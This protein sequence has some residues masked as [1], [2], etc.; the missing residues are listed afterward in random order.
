MYVPGLNA[1]NGGASAYLI[2]GDQLVA[3]PEEKRFNRIK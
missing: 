2:H 1:Y 3:A